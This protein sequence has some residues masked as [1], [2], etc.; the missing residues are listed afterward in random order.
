MS[1]VKLQDK[2]APK[3]L[4]VLIA[5]KERVEQNPPVTH[6]KVLE[7]YVKAQGL[8]Y[9]AHVTHAILTKN[10]ILLKN[11]EGELEWHSEKTPNIHMARELRK[12]LV[13][14]Q[15]KYQNA[16]KERKKEER[17]KT[18]GKLINTVSDYDLRPLTNPKKPVAI[19][20]PTV[21]K[22]PTRRAR[23]KKLESVSSSKLTVGKLI[24][25]VLGIFVFPFVWIFWTNGLAHAFAAANPVLWA[26]DILIM[27]GY[28]VATG[29]TLLGGIAAIKYAYFRK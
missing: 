5:I 8:R 4:K 9:N 28:W 19:P 13:E 2:L 25:Y 14:Y 29:L 10:N 11:A 17:K 6:L 16:Y 3:Y 22:L 1:K 15:A 24:V 20:E 23:T 26:E 21:M 12:A 27:P 18:H 7:K